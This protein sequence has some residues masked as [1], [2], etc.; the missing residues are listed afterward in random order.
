MRGGKKE[1][2]A[3]I[4]WNPSLQ[5]TYFVQKYS[6]VT[7][8]ILNPTLWFL[9]CITYLPHTH[10]HTV[11]IHKY[12]ALGIWAF[13]HFQMCV[14]IYTLF[15]GYINHVCWNI[16]CGFCFST[17]CWGNFTNMQ[18][19][20]WDI[21]FRKNCQRNRSNLCLNQAMHQWQARKKHEI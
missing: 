3:I 8:R 16:V 15:E 18:N 12:I 6:G 11:C 2:K 20:A 19:L 9:R 1:H 5:I 13:S 4:S 14:Y 21:C 10:T 17:S 7:L